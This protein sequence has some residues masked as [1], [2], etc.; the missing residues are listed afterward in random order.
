MIQ[1]NLLPAE[2]RKSESTPI[3]RFL[4]ILI[5]VVVTSATICSYLYVHFALVEK[6]ETMRAHKEEFYYDQKKNAEHS[7][8]LQREIDDFR[9]RRTTIESA[10][11]KRVVWSRKLDELFDVLDN[12]ASREGAH[13]IWLTGLTAN[14]AGDKKKRRGATDGGGEVSFRG[15]SASEDFS[16]LANFRDDLQG[17]A[18]FEDFQAIDSPAWAVV[19]FND[20]L[21]PPAAGQIE[22]K[23][24]LKPLDWRL[25]ETKK[26]RK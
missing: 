22:H 7:L 25:T 17:H 24:V 21:L 23:L 16:R 9:K 15:F 26:S 2:Y 19:R 18:F 5:G 3:L 8:A 12:A 14:V 13:Q 20:D 11:R 10:A 6:W 1:V 4:A